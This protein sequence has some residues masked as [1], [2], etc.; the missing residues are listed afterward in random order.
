MEAELETAVGQFLELARSYQERN[1][2]ASEILQDVADAFRNMRIA[3]ADL[4]DDGDML[5]LEWGSGQQ[6]VL[7]RP[8]DLRHSDEVD[9]ESD[10]A[11]YLAFTRQISIVDEDNEDEE[12]DDEAIQMRLICVYK[13]ESGDKDVSDGN[14]WITEPR[15]LE[16]DLKKFASQRFVSQ[17]IDQPWSRLIAYVD[18]CG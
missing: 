4:D 9:L 1:V 13:S 11:L 3:G 8:T 6:F 12:F 2:T 16:R 14:L 5:L 15:R 10:E 18:H 17:R 7:D